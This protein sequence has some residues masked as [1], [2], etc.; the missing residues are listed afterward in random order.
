AAGTPEG[1]GIAVIAGTGSIAVGRARDG[2]KA[3]AGGWGPLMGDEGSAYDV[4]LAAL[5]LVARRADGRE[6][7]AFGHDPLTTE[8]CQALGVESPSQIVS[9]LYAPGFDRTRIAS[10]APVVVAAARDDHSITG[11][12]LRPAGAALAEQ[13]AA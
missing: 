7:S 13:A 5:R 8:V 12:I 3:R 1:W 4:V 10:L 11:R 2:R 6:A 9:R